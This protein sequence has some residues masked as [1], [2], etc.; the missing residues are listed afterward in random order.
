MGKHGCIEAEFVCSMTIGGLRP[1]FWMNVFENNPFTSLGSD[2]VQRSPFQL[3]RL[4]AALR[5]TKRLDLTL[6][7]V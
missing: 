6:F 3:T 7:R 5:H 4:G 1:Q 2:G